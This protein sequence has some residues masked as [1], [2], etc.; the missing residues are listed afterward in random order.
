[1]D[2]VQKQFWKAHKAASYGPDHSTGAGTRV[3]NTGTAEEKTNPFNEWLPVSPS[4]LRERWS[5]E[6][7]LTSQLKYSH[8][9]QVLANEPH[10]RTPF[11]LPAYTAHGTW[12][13]GRVLGFPNGVDRAGGGVRHPFFNEAPQRH[14][15]DEIHLPERPFDIL[16]KSIKAA[17]D[18]INTGKAVPVD[19]NHTGMSQNTTGGGVDS[20]IRND[21]NELCIQP[22]GRKRAIGCGARRRGR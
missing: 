7:A 1:M 9:K 22:L 4:L 16:E 12:G 15:E 13:A 2:E 18:S 10:S 20:H 3:D 8:S 21:E 5:D 11:H 6:A 17:V 19:P 14:F